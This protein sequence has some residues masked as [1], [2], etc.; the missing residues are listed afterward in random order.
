MLLTPL[1]IAG[2]HGLFVLLSNYLSRYTYSLRLQLSF[3]D[4]ASG[5]SWC[6]HRFCLQAS[7]WDLRGL[8]AWLHYQ[9]QVFMKL[10][11]IG[12]PSYL[13]YHWKI[14]WPRE[15]PQFQ[16]RGLLDRQ[17]FPVSN[18]M[19]SLRSQSFDLEALSTHSALG[20]N[21]WPSFRVLKFSSQCFS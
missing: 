3:N 6:P 10:M 9:A 13:A 4:F 21:H 7:V 20:L 15:V 8:V 1:L 16:L 5:Q 18:W 14:Y 12:L 17:S 2:V 11:S 19:L